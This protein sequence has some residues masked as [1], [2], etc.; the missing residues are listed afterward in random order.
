VRVGAVE[1]RVLCAFPRTLWARSV[2]PQVR[3]LPHAGARAS[4]GIKIGGLGHV[5]GSALK[6]Q[7]VQCLA[8]TCA[9]STRSVEHIPWE[10]APR[11]PVQGR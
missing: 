5:D 6:A 9:P 2:R 8:E 7:H 4:Y 1:K 11:A 3:Q 10:V